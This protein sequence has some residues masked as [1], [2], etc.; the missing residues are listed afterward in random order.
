MPSIH[1]QPS[2]VMAAC[3][4]A[5]SFLFQAASGYAQPAP[6]TSVARGVT[7][8]I[9]PEKLAADADTWVFAVTLDA[10]TQELADDLVNTVVLVTDD[11][12]EVRPAAWN[13]QPPGGH[14]REGKL[15]FRAPKPAPKS[16]ELRMRRVGETEPR[17][18]RWTL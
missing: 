13:G 12:R 3:L 5:A 18:F 4:A 1:L 8:K 9:T 6:A 16:V 17:T 15:E 2:R 10:H 14:H 11:G 7:V